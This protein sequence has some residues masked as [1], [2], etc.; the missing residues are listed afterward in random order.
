MPQ[1]CPYAVGG[2]VDLSERNYWSTVS[3]NDDDTLGIITNAADGQAMITVGGEFISDVS[4][5]GTA[6]NNEP[7]KDGQIG[8][9]LFDIVN[10]GTAIWLLHADEGIREFVNWVIKSVI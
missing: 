6:S 1:Y 4:G 5:F 3:L 9:D 7:L 10:Q 8:I 2:G